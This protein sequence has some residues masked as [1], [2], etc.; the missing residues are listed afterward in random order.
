M[1]IKLRA[2]ITD[3]ELI[4]EGLDCDKDSLAY[5]LAATLDNLPMYLS[6]VQLD[7]DDCTSCSD[8][9]DEIWDLEQEVS[10]LQSDIEDLDMDRLIAGVKAAKQAVKSAHNRVNFILGL[11]VDDE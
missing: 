6:S 11:G 10:S 5:R 3:V 2:N 9:K 7:E 4:D 8:L 1:T